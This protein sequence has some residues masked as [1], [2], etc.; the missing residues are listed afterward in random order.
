MLHQAEDKRNHD[1]KEQNDPI[2]DYQKI[3]SAHHLNVF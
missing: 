1:E 2:H 3:N